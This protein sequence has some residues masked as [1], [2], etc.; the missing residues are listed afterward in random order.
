MAAWDTLHSQ[1]YFIGGGFLKIS[2]RDPSRHDWDYD[3]DFD[4]FAE[5][6]VDGEIIL[7]FISI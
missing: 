7:I 6:K 4:P 3:P 2:Q 1:A 5:E